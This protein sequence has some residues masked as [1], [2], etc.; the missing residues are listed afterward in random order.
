MVAVAI[1]FYRPARNLSAGPFPNDIAAHYATPEPVREILHRACYDCHSDNTRYPWYVN[2]QPVGWWMGS[3]I[4]EAK[5]HLN[6]SEFSAYSAKRAA[7][8]MKGVREEVEKR[9][10]PLES[11]TIIHRD[12]KLTAAEIRLV[13]DWARGIEDEIKQ[14][15]A[16]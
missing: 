3:H 1:Q 4:R 11:Y 12:A 15:P 7:S 2:V 14:A 6:F 9:D 13:S 8:K 16:N 10:M 5:R